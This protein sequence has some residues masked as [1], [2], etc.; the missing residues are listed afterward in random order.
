MAL[1]D[2]V[3]YSEDVAAL[4]SIHLSLMLVFYYFLQRD[5]EDR[6]ETYEQQKPIREGGTWR[7]NT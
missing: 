1:I 6:D 7:E 2:N 5:K 3:T 4:S